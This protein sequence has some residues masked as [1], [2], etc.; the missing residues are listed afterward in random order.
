MS[1]IVVGT[2]ALDNVKT[3][4]G[5]KRD[6][7][8]GSAAHFSMSSRLFTD[9]HLVAVVGK[10]FPTKHL[11]FLGNKGVDLTSLKVGEGKTF[12]W[13]G[14]YKPGDMNSALTL[15]TELGVLMG[16]EPE[17]ASHQRNIT[18]VFLANI[19]PDVQMGL[20]KMMKKPH[21]V[22]LDRR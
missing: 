18:N 11:R 3:P 17:V 21:L 8:G 9:V 5:V 6:M 12:R 15:A 10:D 4:S 14:E 19:D 16:Y 13:D 20:L 1:L 7:L 22:G 2:V